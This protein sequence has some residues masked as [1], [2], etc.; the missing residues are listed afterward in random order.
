M[1]YGPDYTVVVDAAYNRQTPYLPLYEHNVCN[2]FFDTITGTAS[3]T[4]LQGDAKDIR[5]YF[6]LFTQFLVD[7]GYDTVP[8]EGCVVELI[9]QGE[10]LMG[11]GKALFT[12]YEDVLQYPWAQMP[13]RYF[14]LYSVYFDALATEMPA[15]MKAVGG[16]G[17]GIFE[18][19]QDFVPFTE[20][21]Y[22][23]V[24]EPEAFGLLFTRVSDMLCAI[25]DQF[26]QRYA[27]MYAVC[28]FG[29]DLGFKSSTLLH[30]DVIR[31]NIL[32][33]YKKII[34]QV[35]G[36]GK[37]FLLHNC[38]NIFPIM[39]DIIATG[40]D[41][42]HSNEDS[43]A[44]FSKWVE[45]YGDRIGNFGGIDMNILCIEDEASIKKYVTEVLR[46]CQGRDGL[47]I[48]SGNQIADYVPPEGFIAMVETVLE[49]RKNHQGQ[50]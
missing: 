24:D 2:G 4:L 50:E 26:L 23:M 9:Q 12:S 47:A 8:F 3:S 7:H 35:H 30:P 6:K 38:G 29:D 5:Q 48:G 33:A 14:D 13:T 45:L 43:I 49:W 28:R 19:V 36:H 42:K 15:G 10:G 27:E 46:Y 16:V 11:H 25:W 40:I 1:Q 37:P 34:T 32:P 17:N 20:L 44:P 31:K 18:T 41:A 21:A 39:E 22:L